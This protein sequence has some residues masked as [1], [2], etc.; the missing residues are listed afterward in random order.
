MP[1]YKIVKEYGRIQK[2]LCVDCECTDTSHMIRFKV[3]IPKEGEEFDE[4]LSPD[5][6]GLIVETQLCSIPPFYMRAINS[7][8]YLCGIKFADGFYDS[9]YDDNILEKLENVVIYL[10]KPRS[11]ESN[12]S[13]TLMTKDDILELEKLIQEV[14]ILRGMIDENKN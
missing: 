1:S 3:D 8:K 5:E 6:S 12:W 11:H 2:I 10:F 13:C 9:Q 14:K 4:F 7:I